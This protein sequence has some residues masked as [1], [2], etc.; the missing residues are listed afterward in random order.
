M[1]RPFV[2]LPQESRRLLMAPS[3]VE[4]DR[5]PRSLQGR[6]RTRHSRRTFRSRGAEVTYLS[7]SSHVWIREWNPLPRWTCH[8]AAPPTGHSRYS[9]G[10][11]PRGGRFNSNLTEEAA[12]LLLTLGNLPTSPQTS[13]LAMLEYQALNSYSFVA[14]SLMSQRTCCGQTI[15]G[16]VSS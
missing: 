10:H 7:V 9:F 2:A 12:S 13:A 14:T 6:A 11:L 15:P 3:R 4:P 1:G 5:L 8:M 16:P